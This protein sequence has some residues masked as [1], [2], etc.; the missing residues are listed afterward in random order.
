MSDPYLAGRVAFKTG[1]L[2]ASLL[3]PKAMSTLARTVSYGKRKRSWREWA[4]G[5]KMKRRSIPK[6]L[7]IKGIHQFKRSMVYTAAYIPSTGIAGGTDYGVNVAC[8][9]QNCYFSVQTGTTTTA[10]PGYSELV[11]LFDQYR[12]DKMTCNVF[13]QD[14][15]SNTGSALTS[16]PIALYGNDVNDTLAGYYPTQPVMLQFATTK[17]Y[18][19]GN[20]A[21]K[22]GCLRTTVVPQAHLSSGLENGGP[23][24]VS[25]TGTRPEKP[26]TW[27]DTNSPAV[28]HFGTNFWFDPAGGTQTTNLGTFTFYVD[29]YISCKDIN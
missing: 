29:L 26:R 2:A 19:F 3:A 7:Y 13:F 14:T 28:A 9:L 16:M 21:S 23:G 27:I 6:S 20:G 1:V 17:K 4:G 24:A 8:S 11:S 22:G 25:S 5:K 15:G 12:I 10:V 18:Q